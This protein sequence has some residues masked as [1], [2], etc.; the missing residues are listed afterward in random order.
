MCASEDCGSSSYSEPSAYRNMRPAPLYC[1]SKTSPA[2]CDPRLSN[3][4]RLAHLLRAVD[5]GA[6]PQCKL[7]E[8]GNYKSP[9]QR[10]IDE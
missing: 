5:L 6:T 3:R 2:L 4:I 10:E 9:G 8:S 1:H 7:D